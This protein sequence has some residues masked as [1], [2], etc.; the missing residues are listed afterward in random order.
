M[1]AYTRA[2]S[3]PGRWRRAHALTDSPA[4]CRASCATWGG[5]RPLEPG[6]PNLAAQYV[7]DPKPRKVTVEVALSSIRCQI[8]A[9]N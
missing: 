4:G 7:P 5:P 9:Y 8:L 6:V 3:A 2:G 1:S